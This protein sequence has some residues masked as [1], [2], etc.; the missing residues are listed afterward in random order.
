[1]RK[2]LEGMR[3]MQVEMKEVKETGTAV[4]RLNTH[5]SAMETV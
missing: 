4:D 1:M 2:N 5:T 3:S